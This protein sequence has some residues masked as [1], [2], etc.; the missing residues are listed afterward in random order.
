[1]KK[2]I[3][4]VSAALLLA[5]LMT[6]GIS[7]L[8]LGQ[9][10]AAKTESLA[11]VK[12]GIIDLQKIQSNSALFKSLKTQ[13]EAYA[14]KYQDDAAAKEK[15]IKK[16]TEDLKGLQSGGD[17]DAIKAKED[18]IRTKVLKYRQEIVEN[19]KKLEKVLFE[20]GAKINNEDLM[21]VVGN[22]AESKGANMILNRSQVILYNPNF[23][24]TEEVIKQLDAKK[25]KVTVPD[26]SNQ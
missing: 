10:A 11:A 3:K 23:D 24:I 9:D 16:M 15:E 8:S 5:G 1:M 13:G 22:I 2:Q 20:T 7:N 21:P 12:I 4:Q 17:A 6:S 26:P 18:E 14:K 25:S 19:Q